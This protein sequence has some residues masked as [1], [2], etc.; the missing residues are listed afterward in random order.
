MALLGFIFKLGM[1][2]HDATY[3]LILVL[4]YEYICLPYLTL[5]YC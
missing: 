5:I 2:V 3:K 4:N 1:R